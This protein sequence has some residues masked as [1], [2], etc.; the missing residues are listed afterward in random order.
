[1]CMQLSRRTQL[2]LDTDRYERVRREAARRGLSVGA[3]IRDAI[4]VALPPGDEDLRRRR[5]AGARLLAGPP[6]AGEREPDWEDVK[7]D[8]LDERYRRWFP[9]E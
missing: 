9:A 7:N 6:P 1:M 8:L 4:D 3:V 2:L 5:E